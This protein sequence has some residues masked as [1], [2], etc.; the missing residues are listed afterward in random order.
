MTLLI[1]AATPFEIM[2][3]KS[4][5]EQ[6]FTSPAP[7]IFAKEEL[8]IRLL[9]T[10]IGQMLTGYAM[11]YAIAHEDYDFAINAG[12]A[13]AHN[14]KL[15]VGQVVNVYSEQFGDLGAEDADGSFLSIHDLGLLPMDE[16]PFSA[17]K[18]LNKDASAFDFLPKVHGVTV[19]KVHG[20]E[21]TIASDYA[22]YQADVE[23][24][25]GAAFAYICRLHEIPFLQIRAISNYV[26]ARNRE[27]WNL[28]LAITNLNQ[29][30]QQ[31]VAIF[32]ND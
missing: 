6:H 25:E 13:G 18:I 1:V 10:G 16:A 11:G 23:S 5:L 12:V 27:A 8:Q 28:P 22:R 20:Y 26:E 15:E 9:I 21:P 24:M 3:L 32:S 30:L 19:N 2:P 7:N 17:G 4:Y 29:V 31:I 14:R